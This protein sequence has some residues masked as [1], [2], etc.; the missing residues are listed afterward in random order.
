MRRPDP[1]EVAGV[2][3]AFSPLFHAAL[4]GRTN[5]LR[6]G[7]AVPLTWRA[8]GLFTTAILR[9]SFSRR[10]A[11]EVAFPGGGPEPHDADLEATAHRELIEEIGVAPARTFGR[12]SSTPVYTSEWRLEP[13]VVELPG[14]AVPVPSPGEVERVLEL[15]LA[16]V[17]AGG[18]VETLGID[19]VRAPGGVVYLP[20]F[21]L[22]GML[23][24][25]ATAIVLAELL[26]V[27]APAFGVA[28]PRWER[29]PIDWKEVL[30]K[31]AF[32]VA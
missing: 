20:V 7:V 2:I 15:D 5:H 3:G 16:A 14:D 26:N 23:M 32:T 24:Y 6:A 19:D 4:P 9:P 25:G 28:A 1:D 17:L 18:V 8:D 30:V 22:D 27:L 31:G 29:G 11:S 10:H 12:L 13:F 21:R